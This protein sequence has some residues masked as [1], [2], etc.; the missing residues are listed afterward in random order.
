MEQCLFSLHIYGGNDDILSICTLAGG[1]WAENQLEMRH[2]AGIQ[3]LSFWEVREAHNATQLL[4]Y[5]A[6]YIQRKRCQIF[7]QAIV[8]REALHYKGKLTWSRK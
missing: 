7:F 1:E 8:C 3:I 2:G 6:R 5:L 4:V